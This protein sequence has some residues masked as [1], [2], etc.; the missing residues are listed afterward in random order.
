M[1]STES[2]RLL[3]YLYDHMTQPKFQVRFKW[4]KNTIAMWDNR[5]TMHFALGDYLPY[6]RKMHRITITKDRRENTKK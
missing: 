4:A 5:C 6:P 1:N 2:R 3:N